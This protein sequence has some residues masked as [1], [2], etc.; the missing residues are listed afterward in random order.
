MMKRCFS[1]LL[2]L[3]LAACTLGGALPAAAVNVSTY[4]RKVDGTFANG[5]VVSPM[6]GTVS[7]GGSCA[8]K[9]TAPEGTRA[10]EW[11]VYT[12]S[13]LGATGW[14]AVQ[15]R[16]V[17]EG[18]S[19]TYTMEADDLK[20]TDVPLVLYLIKTYA[21]T[22][23]ASPSGAGT[24]TIS[25]TNADDGRADEGASVTL[26]ANAKAGYVFDHWEGDAADAENQVTISRVSKDVSCTAVFRELATD[27]PTVTT[28][29]T[30][31][32]TTK[33]CATAGEHYTV[34]ENEKTDA[35]TYTFMATLEKG[36]HWSDDKS[37]APYAVQWTIAYQKVPVTYDFN[38]EGSV[39]STVDQNWKTTYANPDCSRTSWEF[40]GWWTEREGGVEV[41][42]STK[43]ERTDAHTLYAHWVPL[44]TYDVTTDA[45]P[46]SAGSV[47]GGG[48]HGPGSRVVLTARPNEGYSFA[49]WQK[50]EQV[51][52]DNPLTFTL[53]ADVACTAV[54]TGNVYTVTFMDTGT[55]PDPTT[56]VTY[57][58]AYGELLPHFT[59]PG[60]GLTGWWTSD[61]EKTREWVDANTTVTTAGNHS[62]YANWEE[63]T[64]FTVTWRDPQ[65]DPNKRNDD[66]VQPNVA[67][68]TPIDVAPEKTKTWDAQWNHEAWIAGWNPPLPQTVTGDL[69]FTAVTETIGSVLDCPELKFQRNDNWQVCTNECHVGNSCLK[70]E[71]SEGVNTVTTSLSEPGR[72]T[73]WWKS[74]TKTTLLVSSGSSNSNY[75]HRTGGWQKETYELERAGDVRITCGYQQFG[76][77]PRLI[78]DFTWEPNS[79]LSRTIQIESDGHGTVVPATGSYDLGAPVE[80]TAM[81]NDGYAFC[82]WTND[83]G[84]ATNEN[85]W[86]FTVTDDACY[87]ATFTNA[88]Y[89]VT[90]DPNG[91]TGGDTE[92]IVTYDRPMPPLTGLP[93]HDAGWAFNG[94]T[95]ATG[96][97]YY[98]ADGTSARV[99]D[100]TAGTTLAARWRTPEVITLTVTFDAC[101]GTVS[102]VTKSFTYGDPY[103]V[104]ETPTSPS[105][106]DLVFDGWYTSATG[107]VKIES[108]M[109]VILPGDHTLF[110]HW[111][112]NVGELS[113]ALDCDNLK[114][115]QE[116]GWEIGSDPTLG[117]LNGKYVYTSTRFA[118][119]YTTNSTA[120]T[121]T[122]SY[123]VR[124]KNTMTVKVYLG[125]Q[126]ITS[127]R[128][129]YDENKEQ[130]SK[131]TPVDV[132]I[133]V[134][135]NSME[136]EF[137]CTQIDG[138]GDC[139]CAIDNVTW[140]PDGSEPVKPVTTNAVPTAVQGLVYDG[141]AKTG[142]VEGVNCTIAGNV[143]TEAGAHTAIA[144]VTNGV[145]EG[146]YDGPTNIE[147]TIAKATYDMKD[148]VFTNETVTFDGLPH[149]LAVDESTLPSGVTVSYMGNG[150]T[151]VGVHTVTA[152][153]AGDATNYEAISN[154]T[155]TLTILPPPEPIATNAVPE[156]VQGLVYDGTEKIGVEEGANY[157]VSG[158]VATNAGTYTAVATVTNGVWEG[159]CDG[160]TNV[161]WTI[162]KAP[163]PDVSGVSFADATYE[164]DGASHSI[165]VSGTV[166]AG[167]EVVYSGDATN[168]TEVGTNTV[169]ASF[170]VLDTV[171]YCEITK[172]LTATLAITAKE[173]PPTPPDPPAP[174]L[175]AYENIYF[176]ATLSELGAEAV[177]TNRKIT[178]K[179]EGLPK[180]LKLV[181]T[182]LKDAK[183]KATGYY[184]YTV[185]GVPTE[186][187]DGSSRMA[188]VRVTDNK[189]Q[190]LYAL[191]LAVLWA[192]AYEDKLFPDG[193]E[194]SAYVNFSVTNL[195]PDVAAHP[196]NWTFSGWPAGIKYATK[197]VTSRQKIDGVNVTLTN[198]LPYEVYGTPTKAGR[199]SVKAV[200]KIVGTSYK[201]THV[202]TFTVWPQGEVGEEWT[203]QAYVGVYRKSDVSVKSASGLPTGVKFT[204]KDI[205]SKE[206]VTTEANHFY[207]TP[208]KAGT[209]AVTLTHDDGSKTQFLWTIT[210]AEA[211][212]FELELSETEV[213]PET[214][215][216]T[217]RAGVEY[218]W[219]ISNTPGSKV[220]ASGLPTGLKLLS[221]PVKEGTKTVG[222]TY[223]VAGVPTKAGEY[224]ATFKTTLNGV[225]VL[226]TAAFTVLDLPVWAQGTFDGGADETFPV[227]GQ[228]TFTVS[229]VGKLS[230]KWMSEGTNWTL[231]AASYDRYDDTTASYVARVVGKAGS[232]KAA[233]VV[234]NEL[235]VA[236]DA[237]GGLAANE[238]FL[239]YQSNW[240]QEPWK[241][242]GTKVAKAPAFEFEPY[243]GA[244]DDHTNDVISLKFAATG[245]VTVKASYFKSVSSAGKISWTTAS[246]SAALC[247]QA[248]PDG[249]T[250]PAVVFVYLPPKKDTPTAD[251]AYAVCVRLQ[252]DGEKFVEWADPE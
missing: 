252:W 78:D 233:R 140:T 24:V 175:A 167:V 199:F 5:A 129:Q 104:L 205:V 110:A 218:G 183:N 190:T 208:T 81:A 79:R 232:G 120:G 161:T 136:L 29:F 246:G 20:E 90:F 188:Y 178:I 196:N 116:G 33:T 107:G 236:E 248:Q 16:R 22:A 239:A 159:G 100:L 192:K 215:K 70:L 240:K 59:R 18:A 94:Y 44:V 148:V 223:A 65:E 220:T 86:T 241:S 185:E 114:F 121:L 48:K 49:R 162:A 155:A 201:S 118:R 1:T 173:E 10:G 138:D 149:S 37:T 103:G 247:P 17:G 119:L 226:R 224:F 128:I 169:T 187:M 230:G 165:A 69:T 122:F 26:T 154:K 124:S 45:S 198:A 212:T 102:P 72:L 135:E 127:K 195:W 221:T 77:S 245:K 27:K 211:P 235:V 42:R 35:G 132:Q 47:T 30:Y 210:P 74:N 244:G 163:A 91:G 225:T 36:Y 186:T 117:A 219:A 179:A 15:Y 61:D 60:F 68:D 227:G 151:A 194:K 137:K 182:A 172:T 191:D 153:F 14:R 139:C 125:G 96:V 160:P 75:V 3:A 141:N 83:T 251:E 99:C 82:C 237:V 57:G 71:P 174:T 145:W 123:K 38:F 134:P 11:W 43:V 12:A 4:Y 23:N 56:N 111:K 209:Y 8:F 249:E 105:P 126:E 228:V 80:L 144:V 64:E 242:L 203:D 184:A 180:G 229:K 130:W 177:P 87:R 53:S 152:M 181:T 88:Q 97:V 142:V 171:N 95:N 131:W 6:Q 13:P 157:S 234:T 50:G 217:I 170:K 31:D 250:F 216:A 193:E 176:K 39:S 2:S 58:S 19:V 7:V 32:G 21:V 9:A 166:P 147:W 204:A 55:S 207:G 93:T 113:E 106:D 46:V 73:F 85:P 109:S 54:F 150:Q 214:A 133:A 28:S 101:G 112:K 202:A 40:L 206:V 92:M 89:V 243:A 62:L 164:F 146:G 238:L 63:K 51:L 143:A 67:I 108:E 231:T 115:E 200:E 34:S 222:Y 189:V 41:T 52:T 156:A 98:G 76:G 25:G 213:D 66:I 197:A 168:R 158:N 84:F